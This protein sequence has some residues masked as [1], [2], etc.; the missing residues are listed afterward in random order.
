MDQNTD[1]TSLHPSSI[2]LKKYTPYGRLLHQYLRKFGILQKQIA[3]VIGVDSSTISVQMS[4]KRIPP[5][6]KDIE[7]ICSFMGLNKKQSE[8]LHFNAFL[9]LN[10]ISFKLD[11]FNPDLG[12]ILYLLHRNIDILGN[13]PSLTREISLF[14]HEKLENFV[15]DPNLE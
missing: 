13:F 2:F 7:K 11:E 5:P 15:P 8:E 4:G 14:L 10:S 9:S 1:N 12:K 3:N 6:G